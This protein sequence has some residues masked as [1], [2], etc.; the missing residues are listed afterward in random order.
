MAHFRVDL[1]LVMEKHFQFEE[2]KDDGRC[3]GPFTRRLILKGK[4]YEVVGT[5][6]GWP[7][8][9]SRDGIDVMAEQPFDQM[10]VTKNSTTMLSRSALFVGP[11]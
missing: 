4:S 1:S 8:S 2:K 7:R 10:V 3:I 6:E 5:A 9:V 11:C